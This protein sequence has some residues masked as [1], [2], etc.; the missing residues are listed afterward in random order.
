MKTT[1]KLGK[2][3]NSIMNWMMSTSSKAPK[4]GEGATLLH[5]TDRTCYEVLSVSEDGMTVELEYLNAIADKSK[6]GGE[7]HQ[8][9]I[10]EPTGNKST[11]VFR[12]GA[13]YSVGSEIN[14]TKEFQSQ[15][16]D[17]MFI[18]L[19]LRKNNP[20]LADKIYAGNVQ[21][22]VV[23]EGITKQRKTYSKMNIIFGVKDYHYDWSF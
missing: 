9:W 14:F 19:W 7:G 21:P 4:V 5:W 12:R 22:S 6:P 2:H 10:L 8:N 17:P 18:G 3:T 20:E 11:V 16:G 15:C 1:M 23:I 13:W